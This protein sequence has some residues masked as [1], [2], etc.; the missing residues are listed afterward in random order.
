MLHCLSF[1]NINKAL[2]SCKVLSELEIGQP[3]GVLEQ[4]KDQIYLKKTVL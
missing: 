3:I 2:R 1:I 4:L